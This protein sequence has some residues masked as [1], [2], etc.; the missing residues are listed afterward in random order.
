MYVNVDLNLLILIDTCICILPWLCFHCWHSTLSLL[1]AAKWKQTDRTNSFTYFLV[2]QPAVDQNS[3]P[4]WN[5]C[6]QG[7]AEEGVQDFY[8]WNSSPRLKI[9]CW[10][11]F[12]LRDRWVTTLLNYCLKCG[13]WSQSDLCTWLTAGCRYIQ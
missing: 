4:G 7:L 5:H 1:S 13:G 9:F 2:N 11:H 6:I 8:Y 3:Q 12:G 10:W